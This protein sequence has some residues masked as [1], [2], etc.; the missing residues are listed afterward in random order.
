MGEF[1]IEFTGLDDFFEGLGDPRLVLVSLGWDSLTWGVA[2]G[3]HIVSGLVLYF[4]S[5]GA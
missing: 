1:I 2:L 4:T 5:S 3:G